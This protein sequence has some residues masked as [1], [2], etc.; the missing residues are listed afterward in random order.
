MK[1]EI[2]TDGA[3]RGNPGP[4][5]V[6]VVIYDGKKKLLE[7]YKECIGETTN[8]T[9]EYRALLAGLKA[10]KKYAPCSITFFL[11]SELVVRQMNG[12]WK[13][14]DANLAGL[15]GQARELL[16]SFERVAFE[17]VPRRHNKLA[18][19]LANQALD[20]AY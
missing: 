17:Y 1:I 3:A 5:A 11:D 18:D 14:R 16:G 10:A 7:E 13:V 2:Y 19:K 4:A 20:E 15:H 9:A 6:G 12:Q 8:N